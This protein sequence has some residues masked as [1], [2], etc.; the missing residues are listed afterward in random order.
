LAPEVILISQERRG[1]QPAVL[2]RWLWR[3]ETL[4]KG[5]GAKIDRRED[6]ME[7]VRELDAPLS[8]APRELM[9]ARRPK[10]TPPLDARPTKMPVTRIERLVRD[11]YAVYAQAILR[12]RPLDLPGAPIDARERGTAVH[13]AFQRLV[14]EHPDLPPDIAAAFERLLIAELRN[15]G[16]EG[17]Q[18]AREEALARNL[19][20]WVEDFERKRRA[21][22]RLIVEQEGALEFTTARGRTFRL[23]A[24]PDRLELRDGAA[25]ILDFKTGSPPT[26]SQVRA[27]F[28]PQLTLTAAIVMGGGFEGS[29]PLEPGELLYVKVSGR[30]IPATE[31]ARGARGESAVLAQAAL[32]GLKRLIDKF[33]L[34]DT[35]YIS[36][37][38]PQ[39]RSDRG[40]DYDH[41]ARLWEWAVIGEDETEEIA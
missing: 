25:D 28:A 4:A 20:R 39:F 3:L 40:G 30:R 5:A 35:P 21:D 23:T 33:E 7:L 31:E 15:V 10:P 9:Q 16:M 1:G 29:G 41:L 2:S 14:E 8:P 6:L 12:L 19:A 27:G 22:T 37:R 34:D 38:A 32:E 24:K 11:P 26:M 36:W 18:L 17:A 13:K